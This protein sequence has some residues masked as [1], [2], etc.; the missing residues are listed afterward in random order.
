MI[1]D[2]A[3]PSCGSVSPVPSPALRSITSSRATT[4]QQT[5]KNGKIGQWHAPK[6]LSALPHA[7]MSRRRIQVLVPPIHTT[8]NLASGLS[9]KFRCNG[10]SSQTAMLLSNAGI[11]RFARNPCGRNDCCL[12]HRGVIFWTLHG[13]K[14]Q[15][16]VPDY[17]IVRSTFI[18]KHFINTTQ[19]LTPFGKITTF[20]RHFTEHA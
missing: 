8:K 7:G 12:Q 19:I 6:I 14:R 9:L 20:N 15:L 13:L 17:E 16:T 10:V 4:R 3:H 5:P 18:I 2:S 1:F 11:R